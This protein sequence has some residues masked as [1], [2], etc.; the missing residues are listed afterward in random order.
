MI[1]DI[2]QKQIEKELKL[3]LEMEKQR[4]VS[5]KRMLEKNEKI[6]RIGVQKEI[7]IRDKNGQFVKDQLVRL[8][9]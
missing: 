6:F 5:D 9:E 8:K 4:E 1:S 2:Q 3:K 7:Q